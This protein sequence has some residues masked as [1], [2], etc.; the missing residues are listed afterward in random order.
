MKHCGLEKKS[1]SQCKSGMCKLAKLCKKQGNC[2]KVGKCMS[3]QLNR[4]ARQQDFFEAWLAQIAA[5]DDPAAVPGEV[6]TGLGRFIRGLA[7]GPAITETLPVTAVPDPAVDQMAITDPD[8]VAVVV[9]EVIPLPVSPFAG[10]RPVVKLLDGVGDQPR[11]LAA[12]DE[13]GEA[14]VEVT[15]SPPWTPDRMT[16]EARDELGMF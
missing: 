10:A 15:L 12:I 5:S 7:S 2:K 16:E 4:L 8:A 1:S 13:V 3:C 6:E 9:T 11:T 14:E